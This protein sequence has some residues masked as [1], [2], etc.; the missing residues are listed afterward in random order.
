M[1]NRTCTRCEKELP[2]T[3]FYTGRHYRPDGISASCKQCLRD[4]NFFRKWGVS[5]DDLVKIYGDKCNICFQPEYAL[6]KATGEIRCRLSVDHDH[7]CCEEGCGKCIRGLLCG[8]CNRRLAVLEDREWVEWA[9]E[10]LD[11][12][13]N[14][15]T[16]T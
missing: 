10:Y 6:D 2:V 4:Y 8:W 9:D 16:S 1:T 3:D 5:Y 7:N 13:K 12:S 15:R 14:K 11:N